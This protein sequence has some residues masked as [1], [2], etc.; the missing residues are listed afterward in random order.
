[1]ANNLFNSLKNG[2]RKANSAP[3]TCSTLA[4]GF[5][6][7]QMAKM[8]LKKPRLIWYDALTKT[9]Y[10]QGDST[11]IKKSDWTKVNHL[12]FKKDAPLNNLQ[13]YIPINNDL[14]QESNKPLD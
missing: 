11:K 10:D 2:L 14:I 1:M 6:K 3:P 12:T 4:L 5:T 8:D 13:Y 7:M 9:F